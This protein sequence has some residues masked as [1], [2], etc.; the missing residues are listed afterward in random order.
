MTQMSRY[1]LTTLS[2]VLSGLSLLTAGCA[3][4]AY[5]E[6]WGYRYY[7]TPIDTYPVAVTAIDGEGYLQQPV[8]VEP[9]KHVISVQ[10]P[11]GGGQNVGSVRKIEMDVKPCYRYYLVA[12]KDN[13]LAQDFSVKVDYEEPM[14]GCRPPAG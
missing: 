5:S 13:R 4:P 11:P 2:A 12:V 14:G 6:L 8:R 3:G 10:A 9:G 1:G 7:V